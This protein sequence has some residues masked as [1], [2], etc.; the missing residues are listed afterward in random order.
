MDFARSANYRDLTVPALKESSQPKPKQA[1]H[2]SEAAG[3][4]L[5]RT[6]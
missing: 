6:A 4:P 5:A 2:E 3:R 1:T